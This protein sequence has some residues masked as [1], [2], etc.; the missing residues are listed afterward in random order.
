MP[1]TRQPRVTKTKST[2]K[3]GKGTKAGSSEVGTA[4]NN[5]GSSK[6]G[7]VDNN[8]T[9]PTTGQLSP[10]NNAEKTPQH[11]LKVKQEDCKCDEVS[12]GHAAVKTEITIKPEDFLNDF[13]LEMFDTPD[14]FGVEPDALGEPDVDIYGRSNYLDADTYFEAQPVDAAMLVKSEVDEMDGA[15]EPEVIFEKAVVKM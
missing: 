2:T 10:S 13:E 3:K 7:T 14:W 8:D 11:D 9:Y 1:K 15:S 4:D 6:A 12:S 5:A